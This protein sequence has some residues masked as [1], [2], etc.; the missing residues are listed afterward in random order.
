MTIH[1]VQTIIGVEITPDELIGYYSKHA[2]EK[3]IN[4]CKEKL[5]I[6][7][8]KSE[9]DPL[10]LSEMINMIKPKDDDDF[11]DFMFSCYLEC[12]DHLIFRITHDIDDKCPYVIG[13]PISDGLS[14]NELKEFIKEREE[15]LKNFELKGEIQT[16]RIQDDCECCS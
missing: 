10:P 1:D 9:S 4:F 12:S 8:M 5:D 7:D 6:V 14:I 3:M 16:F 2:T 13:Y 11:I 15:K